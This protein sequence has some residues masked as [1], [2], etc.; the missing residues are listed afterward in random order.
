MNLNDEKLSALLKRWREIEPQAN[1]EANVWR[2]IKLSQ[3]PRDEGLTL[4]DWLRQ[5]L[6]QPARALAA[7][8]V[9]SVL[10]GIAGGLLTEANSSAGAPQSELRF[11]SPGTLAGGY[12]RLGAGGAR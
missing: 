10:V 7:A 1:F 12:V 8:A 9:V 5:L 3:Q 2:R 4:S 11:L 6:W